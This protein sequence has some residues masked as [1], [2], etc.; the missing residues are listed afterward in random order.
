MF[1]Q[2]WVLSAP[3]ISK[4]GNEIYSGFVLLYILPVFVFCFPKS[5]YSI[6]LINADRKNAEQKNADGKMLSKKNAD[7]KNAER[8]NAEQKNAERKRNRP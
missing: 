3:D 6:C 5:G 2:I 8:K 1:S 4:Y 7:R